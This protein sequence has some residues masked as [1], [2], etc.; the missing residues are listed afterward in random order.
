MPSPRNDRPSSP[1]SWPR[2]QR[3]AVH[4]E[5]AYW[6][7]S[8][9]GLTVCKTTAKCRHYYIHFVVCQSDRADLYT[10]ACIQTCL[11][12]LG[13][14]VPGYSRSTM[15]S[16]SIRGPVQDTML[17]ASRD[18]TQ[19]RALASLVIPW[20]RCVPNGGGPQNPT[21]CR[22]GCFPTLYCGKCNA[23]I[24]RDL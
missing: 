22:R 10:V 1:Y 2:L 11:E 6:V 15:L 19:G 14:R 3:L 7:E 9:H 17:G 12:L 24:E 5:Q 21:V 16:E 8:C 23:L 4:A 18:K 13:Q 20:P